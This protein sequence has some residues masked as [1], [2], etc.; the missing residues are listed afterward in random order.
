[1]DF[2]QNNTG[3]TG[4]QSSE[5]VSPS[6]Q[7]TAAISERP[8]KRSGWKIFWG[9]ILAL[10]VL[11]NIVLFLALIGVV[12]MLAA[13]QKGIFIEEVIQDGPRTTKIAVINVRGIID[14]NQA[15]DV[16]RQLKTAREDKRVK[17]I[18]LR[19]NSPGG[20]I[21]GSDQIYN[22]ILKYRKKEDKPVVAFCLQPLAWDLHR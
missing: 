22:E 15:Q 16:Y 4:P 14:D 10:S 20:T 7:S 3:P 13:G 11:A 19:V 9:V 6:V 5:P 21:S 18:I 2:E 1:M 8:R 12:A 17:G